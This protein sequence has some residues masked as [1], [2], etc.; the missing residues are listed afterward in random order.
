MNKSVM[1][2]LGSYIL[3]IVPYKYKISGQFRGK[4]LAK[5]NNKRNLA[6]EYKLVSNK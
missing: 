2:K 4:C 3:S 6:P 1:N 5:E